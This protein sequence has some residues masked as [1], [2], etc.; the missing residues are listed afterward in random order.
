MS[1]L[2]ILRPLLVDAFDFLYFFY[3]FSSFIFAPSGW[4]E[5]ALYVSEVS[6]RCLVCGF[7]AIYV[8]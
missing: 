6:G 7:D 5:A 1:S 4:P 8:G 2:R 3:S